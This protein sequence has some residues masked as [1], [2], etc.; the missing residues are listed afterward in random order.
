MIISDEMR[1]AIREAGFPDKAYIGDGAYVEFDGYRLI[2][3]T[4]DGERDTNRI[5]LEPVVFDK[6]AQFQSA[7]DKAWKVR[8]HP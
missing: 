3:T 1:D 7:I 6:L 8:N 2:L 4:S 5:A